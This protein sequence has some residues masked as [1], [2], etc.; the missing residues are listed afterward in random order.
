MPEYV[1]TPPVLEPAAAIVV[2]ILLRSQRITSTATDRGNAL[3]DR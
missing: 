3:G 2:A 1:L